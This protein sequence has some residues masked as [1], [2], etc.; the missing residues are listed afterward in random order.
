MATAN[1]V[2]Q[3]KVQQD[4]QRFNIVVNIP[5]AISIMMN[6]DYIKAQFFSPDILQR[7][8]F[9]ANDG[10]PLKLVVINPHAWNSIDVLGRYAYTPLQ[11]KCGY[12]YTALKIGPWYVF[13]NFSTWKC[14]HNKALLLV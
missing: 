2:V 4:C 11:P 1:E 14:L 9:K 6:K 7:R 8:N 12:L 3:F 13:F 10:L 5:T